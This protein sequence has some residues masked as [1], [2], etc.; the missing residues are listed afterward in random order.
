M[1]AGKLQTNDGE[2]DGGTKRGAVWDRRAGM[3]V[4]GTLTQDEVWETRASQARK[5]I[6]LLDNGAS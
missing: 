6:W 2:P 1:F 4:H 5:P 3:S